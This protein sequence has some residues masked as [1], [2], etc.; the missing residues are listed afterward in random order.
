MKPKILFIGASTGGPS[1]IEKLLANLD[2]INYTIVIAQHMR[3]EILPTYIKNM[4]DSFSLPIYS[5]P[6]KLTK[7]GIFICSTSCSFTKKGTALELITDT[8]QQIY[9]P[10]INTLL[11]SF[12]PYAKE[13]DVTVIILSGIGSDGVHGVEKLKEKSCY[14]IAQD[15]ATSPVYGMPKAVFENNLADSV[16]S[17]DDIIRYVKDL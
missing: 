12:T 6:S 9:T 2:T 1:L 17:F 15:E 11:N 4:Q 3:E 5:A 16:K 7:N 13:F 8:T 14:I 10:D